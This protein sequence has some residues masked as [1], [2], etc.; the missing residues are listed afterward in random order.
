MKPEDLYRIVFDYGTP[1]FVF[2]EIEVRERAKAIKSLLNDGNTGREINLCF[3]IKANPFL[4]PALVD[5]VDCFEVCSPGELEIC[6]S[7]KVPG[8]MIIYSGVNKGF[9]DVCEAIKYGAKILTAESVG[10]YSEIR[11]AVRVLKCNVNVI[12]RLNSKSQFGMSLEDIESIFDDRIE[13]AE[14]EVTKRITITGLHYFAGTQRTKLKR[15]RE[16]LAELKEVF[17]RLEEKYSLDLPWFEYGP[18][19]AFPYFE[20]EDDSDTLL[21]AKE[22]AGD[23]QALASD[24]DVT[25][26]M[27]RFLASSCGYYITSIVDMKTADDHNWIIVDGGIN[28]VNYLGSMMGLKIPKI[29]Y[30]REERPEDYYADPGECEKMSGNYTICGSL[31][32]TADVLVRDL[33]LEDPACGETLVFSNIGAYSVTEGIYLFLGRDM[34]KI[35]MYNGHA[36]LARDTVNTWKLNMDNIGTPEDK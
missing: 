15:Q 25:V 35:I 7:L 14:S 36:R 24:R 17:N 26:E 23:I 20:G 34:P 29:E 2:D 8:E 16:E 4:I 27:G 13:N 28:H 32:T 5:V 22:L 3:S 21:P 10:Q 6:K 31:C 9:E 12:L 11:S 30:I 1:S 18:G 33:Y 19:F